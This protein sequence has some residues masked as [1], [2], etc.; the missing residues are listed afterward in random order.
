MKTNK[1]PK[2]L[3][4]AIVMIATIAGCVYSGNVER[5]DAVLSAMSAE[6]YQYIHDR[7]GRRA[8]SSDV[9]KEYLHNQRFYDSRDY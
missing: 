2:Y 4:T 1:L 6:K 7:I 3:L 8:S 5:D 9:V